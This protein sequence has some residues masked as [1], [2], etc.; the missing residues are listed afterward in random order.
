MSIGNKTNRVLATQR[1]W[2]LRVNVYQTG[3]F[4]TK[5]MNGCA[6]NTKT[7]NAIFSLNRRCFP[8]SIH[9]INLTPICLTVHWND[10]LML[11]L[12]FISIT[13][14]LLRFS[15]GQAGFWAKM[16]PRKLTLV[17]PTI[18]IPSF[19]S[20]EG[21]CCCHESAILLGML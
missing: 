9:K 16:I 8:W 12:Y 17:P 11:L 7:K 19:V 3:Q 14:K 18:L 13:K 5:Q 20:Q 4:E 21:T 6:K 2:Y 1:I 10:D 15:D